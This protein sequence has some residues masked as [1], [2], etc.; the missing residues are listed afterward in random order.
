MGALSAALMNR[1]AR[2]LEC[3]P[4]TV[5]I[6]TDN[7]LITIIIAK[8]EKTVSGDVKLLIENINHFKN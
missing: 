1:R 5:F 4:E 7:S 8:K 6:Q 2:L 3:N